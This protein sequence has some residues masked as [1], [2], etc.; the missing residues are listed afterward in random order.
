M[1][2][3]LFASPGYQNI[4]RA[5]MEHLASLGLE[6][7]GRTVLELGAGVGDLTEFWLKRKCEV[8]S[9]EGRNENIIELCRRW[10]GVTAVRADV[11]HAR[12]CSSQDVVF[13][14]G[15]LYH[16]SA[17]DIAIANWASTCK[18]LFLLSTC[19]TPDW[20][21][22]EG[23]HYVNENSEDPTA[24]MSGKGCRPTRRWLWGALERHMLYVYC[25]RTQ[26]EH[27]E[28]PVDWTRKSTDGLTRAVFVASSRPLDNP[29]LS[30]ELPMRHDV[31][32]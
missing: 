23:V 17:P 27:E 15:I 32:R 7:E 11:G 28:F 19:V 5:R 9:V 2:I 3:E 10:P 8:V 4:N 18:D 26:P 12:W 16:L 1:S 21:Q 24:S 30:P 13:A 20:A 22:A 14:Y 29:L 31:R 6:I 25:P